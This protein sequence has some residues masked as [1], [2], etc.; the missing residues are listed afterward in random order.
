MYAAA[1]QEWHDRQ[2]SACG[3]A[4]SARQTRFAQRVFT[5]KNAG[6]ENTCNGDGPHP[7]AALF[8]V[9]GTT[10][11]K[12][13]QARSL[14]TSCGLA[15]NVCP[16][17]AGCTGQ[18]TGGS[19]AAWRPAHPWSRSTLRM[20]ILKVNGTL[21]SAISAFSRVRLPCPSPDLRV[22]PYPACP[23]CR[24]GPADREAAFFP[25]PV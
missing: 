21:A 3:A 8:A 20:Y 14:S 13:R 12:K 22:R 25:A 16:A 17:W 7:L 10:C 9:K 6:R 4:I 18:R 1:I 5:A 2:F 15:R 11:K 24:S 23:T 19:T